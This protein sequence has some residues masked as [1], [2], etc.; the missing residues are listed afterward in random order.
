M[1]EGEKLKEERHG[2]GRWREKSFFLVRW[3]CPTYSSNNTL[4]QRRWSCVW[5]GRAGVEKTAIMYAHLI[6]LVKPT[7]YNAIK[8]ISSHPVQML[9]DNVIRTTY[10]PRVLF[11]SCCCDYFVYSFSSFSGSEFLTTMVIGRNCKFT[12]FELQI[13]RV[14]VI[15]FYSCIGAS[16]DIHYIFYI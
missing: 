7:C 1:V 5:L 14:L 13:I 2:N 16:N 4:P 9:Y 6:A 8:G 12:Q 3:V 11:S 10:I 15:S